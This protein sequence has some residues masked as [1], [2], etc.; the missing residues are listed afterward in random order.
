LFRRFV[1]TNFEKAP[2]ARSPPPAM[3]AGTLPKTSADRLPW[4]RGGRWLK[5]DR[6]AR[7]DERLRLLDSVKGVPDDGFYDTPSELRPSLG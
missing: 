4:V 3:I 7:T 5:E 6:L 2:P 1:V